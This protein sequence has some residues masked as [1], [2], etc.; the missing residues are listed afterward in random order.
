MLAACMS[1]EAALIALVKLAAG[2][3]VADD[4]FLIHQ[5]GDVKSR[6]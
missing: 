5:K 2:M 6:G 3:N 1:G 4:S